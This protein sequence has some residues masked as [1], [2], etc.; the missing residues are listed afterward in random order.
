VY[1]AGLTEPEKND[2]VPLFELGELLGELSSRAFDVAPDV[3]RVCKTT[4][5]DERMRP[6]SE[7]EVVPAVPVAQV[8]FRFFTLAGEVADF[9]L[10]K[11]RALERAHHFNVETGNGFLIRQTHKA[12]VDAPLERG[13][14]VQVE[15]V[16]GQM[17]N[18]A[19]DRLVER[20]A[21]R[22]RRLMGKAEDKVDAG[23]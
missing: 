7:P 16:D 12:A 9:V 6:D 14:F 22:V 23:A 21:E 5:A 1:P 8:V 11:T 17:P 13:V 19:A 15:H 20:R 10:R 3:S 18:S 4:L 2:L